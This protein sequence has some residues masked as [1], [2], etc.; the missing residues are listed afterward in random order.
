[1]TQVAIALLPSHAIIGM[2]PLKLAAL[3]LAALHFHLC[4]AK[5]TPACKGLPPVFVTSWCPVEEKSPQL[6]KALQIWH[7][8]WQAEVFKPCHTRICSA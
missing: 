1:M 6:R 2:M 5:N 4:T 8:G 7:K 3:C